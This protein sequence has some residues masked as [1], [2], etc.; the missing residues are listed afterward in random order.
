MSESIHVGNLTSVSHSFCS[1]PKKECCLQEEG[2]G[3]K[4]MKATWEFLW[5]TDGLKPVGP[6]EKL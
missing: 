6:Q 4:N 2:R 1:L 5:P 3:S